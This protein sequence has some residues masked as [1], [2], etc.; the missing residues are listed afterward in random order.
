MP[1]LP[2]TDTD[3]AATQPAEPH[4][5]RRRL[6]TVIFEADT[7]GGKLFDVALIGCILASVLAVM[8]DTVGAFHEQ[9]SGLFNVAEWVFT[10]LFSIEYVL[11]LLCVRRPSAY[12]R[13]FYGVVDLLAVLPTYAAL[14]LPGTH[15]LTVVR[16]LRVLRI[17]RVLKLT[18]YLG[19][20]RLLASAIRSSRRKVV[21]F[22]LFVLTCTVILGSLM[23]VVEGGRHG[24][25]SIPRS[26]YWAIVTLTTVGYGDISPQTPLGQTL[27]AAIMIL[28]YSIIAI[29]TGIVSVEFS[30]AFEPEVS[31]QVC[32]SCAA[33]GHAPGADYCNR[34]GVKL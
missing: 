21:V 4:G 6:H 17:F 20:A 18:Q 5:R 3:A 31:T 25:T 7:P 10:I 34:C 15:Y 30:R 19:E 33:E 11:R 24:F 27:A 9:W 29:P 13:S 26:M 28:G 23:F 12:A 22:L 8:L 14:L 32:P 2:T 16:L 1:E